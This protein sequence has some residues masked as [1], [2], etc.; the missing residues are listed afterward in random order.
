VLKLTNK[1]PVI[2]NMFYCHG[3]ARNVSVFPCFRG[4]ISQPLERRRDSFSISLPYI[5]FI[6]QFLILVM[7]IGLFFAGCRKDQ[8]VEP[9]IIS[10]T[11][12][13]AAQADHITREQLNVT[14]HEGFELKLWASEKLV[15]D[16]VA[17]HAD[18]SGRI[19]ITT[20]NRRRNAELD[21]RRYRPWFIESL[22]LE[23]VDER[24]RFI[25]REFPA[26]KPGEVSGQTL[27]DLTGMPEE[28][29]ILED[30]SG[31]GFANRSTLFIRDFDEP[32]TDVAGAVLTF[33]DDV[34]VGVSPDLWRVRDTTGD[35]YGNQKESISYGFGV[36]LGFGGHGISGLVTGPDGR[37][38]WSIGDVGM[39]VTDKDGKK[40]HY[41][42]QGVVV[43]AEPD[44]SNFEVFAAGLRN[45]HEFDFD[46]YGNL[47]SVDNDG[48]HPGEFE[49]LVYLVDG[50]DSGWRLNWQFG[51]YDDPK[52][53][54]YK[55]LMDEEYYKPR[56]EGQA[57][58]ILPPL[59][60]Y[61]TGPAGMVYNPG[62]ALSKD[63]NDYFFVAEFA[64]AASRSGINAFR[65]RPVGA[66]FE[67][68]SDREVMRG[69]LATG[70]DIGPDG[71]LYFADWMEGWELKQEGRIWRMDTPGGAE[72]ALRHD[73]QNRLGEDFSVHSPGRLSELL[74][75][76]DM[77]VRKKAQFEL[78]SRDDRETLLAVV[79][80]SDHQLARIHGL[81]GMAQIAR[82][83]PVAAEPIT[84]FL[85]DPDDEIRA[86]S[87]KM[88]GDVRYTPAADAIIP[89]LNDENL[90][91]RFFAM[92]ALGRMAW[93]PA[94]NAIVDLL[95][96][97]NDEDV[98]LRHGGAIALQRLDD[99]AAVAELYRHP[100]KAVR[101]AAVVALMRM[102]SPEAAHFL[103]DEDEFIVTSAARAI[104]DDTMLREAVPALAA[105]LDEPRYMNEP[106]IRR[107]INANLYEGSSESSGRLAKFA[108]RRDV[109]E[110]LRIEALQA[111]EVWPEP[112]VLDRVTGDPRGPVHNNTEYAR[113]ALEPVIAEILAE[114]DEEIVIT[115]LNAVS[116]LHA[117][118]SI[119]HILTLLSGSDSQQVRMASLNTLA[120]LKYHVIDEA[121]F[122]ALRDDAAAVRMNALSLIPRL[123]LQQ[124]TAVSLISP[125]FNNGTVTE[126]RTAINTLED[127]DHPSAEEQ[128][129][130]QLGLLIRD[131]LAPE[132]QLDLILAAERS[133]FSELHQL[134]NTYEATKTR[135]DSVSV[136][137]ETLYGGDANRGR[138]LFF[139]DVGAQCI[140]C[141]VVDGEGAEIGPDLSRV[142]ERLSR[143]QFLKA[144]VIPTEHPVSGYTILSITAQDGSLYRGV[145]QR[146]TD[147]YIILTVDGEPVEIS[148]ELISERRH[149]PS[150]MP[151]M[152]EV[153][154][155]SQI[156]DIIEYLSTL[157]AQ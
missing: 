120:A 147:D 115:A 95:S 101:I 134:L 80:H 135:D 55:V 19:F 12:E 68:E 71:A 137:R 17:L 76:A 149:S 37:I 39:S 69:I 108:A 42:R 70:L 94:F 62:T 114:P 87:A 100:S 74:Q 50:S 30:T 150:A 154:S 111:L 142:A 113:L 61:R 148:K 83:S 155:R 107:V 72:S 26:D 11:D 4:I 1:K 75:H 124:E 86:Q 88:L 47:I 53:N 46:Q 2:N 77:R 8:T 122:E 106:L 59:S 51:K 54:S 90:R 56:F 6:K 129:G 57:A 156:R 117:D 7:I 102:E 112:S 29:F 132:L 91:V 141:H 36:N 21:I 133:P 123:G 119:P 33:G 20:T 44:G 79:R 92:E 28:V 58:H 63:W 81:W 121:V 99:E 60:R 89:L 32:V 128:L 97:N 25:E 27:G 10:I 85:N 130:E 48:D 41:P 103:N 138:N 52:N 38:Y 35:G 13:E 3:R 143:E 66:S 96:E 153:L 45:T 146:E 40:W 125:I 116:G 126:L 127:I 16:P 5:V 22:I 64:G 31:N 105:L 82:R 24:I 73:T 14:L 98:Y 65:L 151:A 15:Q 157:R 18:N 140:N 84:N 139:R 67:L 145:F 78:A 34:Y 110:A 131:E 43:R 104:N 23:T 144:I 93:K 109:P 136:Y 152:G 9:E 118:T 49:R